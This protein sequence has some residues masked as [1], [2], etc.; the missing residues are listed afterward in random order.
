MSQ[1]AK[2]ERYINHHLKIKHLKML[3]ELA[4]QESVARAALT[5]HVSQP[6]VSKMLA[7]MELGL[8]VQLFERAG[9]GIRPT[10]FGELMIRYAREILFNLVKAN[11]EMHTLSSGAKGHVRIG[12]LAGLAT[13]TI[14]AAVKSMKA[15]WPNITVAIREGKHVQNIHDLALGNLDLLIGR[16]YIN[17]E[18]ENF[19]VEIMYE[20]P[21]VLVVARNHPLVHRANLAWKDLENLPWIMPGDDSPTH[22]RL[23]QLLAQHN[24]KKP[25]NIIECVARNITIP[26]LSM[27]PH[28]GMLPLS[29]A[30]LYAQQ[31]IL[32]I[33]PLSLGELPAPMGMIWNKTSHISEAQS[34]FQEQIRRALG[35]FVSELTVGSYGMMSVT[36]KEATSSHNNIGM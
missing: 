12:I 1:N 18:F 30:R 24:I 17:P 4:D 26:L 32:E 9:R 25:K 16:V 27:A 7:E 23:L 29:D 20:E 22:Q 3:V 35:A 2:I 36:A 19:E 15:N 34:L 6:A 11:E 31:G 8:D 14:L 28:I 21:L 5:L 10:A 13:Q 33:L